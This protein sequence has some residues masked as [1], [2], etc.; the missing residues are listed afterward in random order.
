MGYSAVICYTWF[1]G[2]LK[3]IGFNVTPFYYLR[4]Y[5]AGTI[6]TSQCTTMEYCIVDPRH[7]DFNNKFTSEI[8]AADFMWDNDI[9][10]KYYR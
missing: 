6:T 8:D 10:P 1:L 9:L 3:A 4:I 7:Y 2:A 5:E